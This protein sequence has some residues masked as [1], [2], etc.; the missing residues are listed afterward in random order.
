M[1]TSKVFL[2]SNLWVYLLGKEDYT[3]YAVID[4]LTDRL[5]IALS[6]QVVGEVGAV[7]RKKFKFTDDQITRVIAYFYNGDFDVV[8]LT[9]EE[10]KVVSLRAAEM[11]QRYLFQYWDSLLIATALF[12]GCDVFYSEDMH[13]DLLIEGQLRIVNPFL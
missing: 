9:S 2:D 13:H 8:S 3:K 7:L 6:V 5:D 1:K 4:D 12:I 10:Y 11:R